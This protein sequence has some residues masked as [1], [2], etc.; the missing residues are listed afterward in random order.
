MSCALN[1]KVR[2]VIGCETLDLCRLKY[3]RKEI[4]EAKS[5]LFV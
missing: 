3:C 2:F 5:V 4:L 1:C